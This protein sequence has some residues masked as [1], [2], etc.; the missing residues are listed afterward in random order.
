MEQFTQTAGSGRRST[1]SSGGRTSRT[2]RRPIRSRSRC[3][4]CGISSSRTTSPGTAAA[5]TSGERRRCRRG[6][7][8]FN[9][10]GEYYYPWHS[11]ALNEFQNFNEG[12]GGLA[13]LLRV[14][15]P[16][17]TGHSTVMSRPVNVASGKELT[18]DARIIQKR[19]PA[20][21]RAALPLSRSMRP[22]VVRLGRRA[23]LLAPVDDRPLRGRGAD[24]SRCPAGR[25]RADLG[26]L[27]GYRLRL[28]PPRRCPVRCST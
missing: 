16:V 17:G 8:S 27:P 10:C 3:R 1:C 11:H 21:A 5:R 2:G 22:R 18:G 4:S 15:P 25:T 26:L 13:T 28:R 20:G 23:A 6:Q 9:R 19:D 24:E 14:D 7:V 12:F